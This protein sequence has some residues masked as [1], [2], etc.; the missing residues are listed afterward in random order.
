MTASVPLWIVRAY[1]KQYGFEKTEAF[2]TAV[3]D[4][5]EHMRIN[6]ELIS[7]ARDEG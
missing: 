3:P 4:E 6:T 1:I 5:R 2:L 7:V